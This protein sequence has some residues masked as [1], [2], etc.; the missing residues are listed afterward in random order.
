MEA[1]N[2]YIQCT[3]TAQFMWQLCSKKNSQGMK[4]HTLNQPAKFSLFPSYSSDN[5]TIL[6]SPLFPPPLNSQQ[7]IHIKMKSHFLNLHVT[8]STCIY[9]F[10]CGSFYDALS[11]SGYTASSGMINEWRFWRA[12]VTG[13]SEGGGGKTSVMIVSFLAKIKIRHLVNTCQKWYCP[14]QLDWWHSM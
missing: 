4:S 11:S 6:Y 2:Y 3:D 5:H 9:I 13:G 7:A 10:I 8:R 14:S 12:I 1:N